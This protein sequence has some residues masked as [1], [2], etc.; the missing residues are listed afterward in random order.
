M[1]KKTSALAWFA[2]LAA[3][4]VFADEPPDKKGEATKEDPAHAEIRKMRDEVL[5]AIE[6]KDAEALIRHLHP[7]VVLTVQEGEKLTTIRK[8]DGVRGYLSRTFAGPN[9]PV[10]SFKPTVSVDELT[11]LHGDSTGIAFGSSTDHYVMADNS[12]F[13]V[14]TRWSATMVKQDGQWKIANLQ[15]SSNPFD[16]AVLNMVNRRTYWY[17]AGAAAGGLLVGVLAMALL[18]RPAT[19]AAG[20][21]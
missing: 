15:V 12:E 21:P 18:R 2:L 8:H 3:G 20:G 16:N 9:A 11:I 1:G 13:D 17:V 6:K 19:R 7:D 5:Q 14:P 4:W 10:K